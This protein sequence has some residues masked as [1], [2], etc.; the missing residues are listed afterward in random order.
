MKPEKNK[1]REKQTTLEPPWPLKAK[2]LSLEVFD[3]DFSP[4]WTPRRKKKVAVVE[5]Y[6][7]LPPGLIKKLRTCKPSLLT[8]RCLLYTFFFFSRSSLNR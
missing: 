7:Q 2:L 8:L 4:L 6:T 3:I 5:V 1:F